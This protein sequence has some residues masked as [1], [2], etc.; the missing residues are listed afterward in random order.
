[1]TFLLYR[2]PLFPKIMSFH[3]TKLL[4][5]FLVIDS[6]FRN[7]TSNVTFPPKN[8]IQSFVC[9]FLS[10]KRPPSFHVLKKFPL[11]NAKKCIFAPKMPKNYFPQNG[12]D[13]DF[14]LHSPMGCT[15]LHTCTVSRETD[16][17]DCTLFPRTLSSRTDSPGEYFS[18][19]LSRIYSLLDNFP[20]TII[21]SINAYIR[22]CIHVHTYSHT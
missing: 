13:E 1:M 11:S 9:Y 3:L 4:I 5:T 21:I 20:T 12:F 10:L 22:M 17:F 2:H 14:L 18:P 16:S 19:V 15:P 8:V 7:F 6:K